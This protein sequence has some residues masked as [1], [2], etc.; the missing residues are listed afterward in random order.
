[1][2]AFL[3]ACAAHSPKT[4]PTDPFLVE[5]QIEGRWATLRAL[6]A[7]PNATTRSLIDF[8]G[9]AEDA[10]MRCNADKATIK[11]LESQ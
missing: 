8:G 6:M 2:S 9:S 4:T 11:S 10:V 1:M 7:D 3:T 5:T